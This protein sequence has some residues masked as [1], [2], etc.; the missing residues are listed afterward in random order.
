MDLGAGEG[1]PGNLTAP[2]LSPALGEAQVSQHLPSNRQIRA[3][4]DSE[5]PSAGG[6]RRT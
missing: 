5:K 2:V 6:H 3:P 4:E 1:T